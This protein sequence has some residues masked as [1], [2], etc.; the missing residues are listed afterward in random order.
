MIEADDHAAPD[1]DAALLDAMHALKEGTRVRPHV[2]VFL[3]FA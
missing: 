1:V 3:G 2:L